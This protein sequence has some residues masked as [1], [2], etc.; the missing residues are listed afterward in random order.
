MIER[1]LTRNQRETELPKYVRKKNKKI[2]KL[3]SSNS[4]GLSTSN[5][6]DSTPS[7]LA[8]DC[9]V[10]TQE[11]PAHV[12]CTARHFSCRVC[13]SYVV[14]RSIKDER[15]TNQF[16]INARRS[17]LAG[18]YLAMFLTGSVGGLH[19]LTTLANGPISFM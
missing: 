10:H 11:A 2:K 13:F 17:S 16:G 5:F 12:F 9:G 3:H 19:Y 18:I 15:A 1:S 6:V 4:R 8:G 7:P 14:L